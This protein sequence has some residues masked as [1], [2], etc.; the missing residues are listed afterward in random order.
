[1]KLIQNRSSRYLFE[2]H[3][4]QLKEHFHK[5]IYNIVCDESLHYSLGYISLFQF[6]VYY[7]DL[8]SYVF[9]LNKKVIIIKNEFIFECNK[10][11]NKTKYQKYWQEREG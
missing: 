10:K 4:Y 3:C 2:G 6:S 11:S 9:H 8:L 7:L 1:M 5:S